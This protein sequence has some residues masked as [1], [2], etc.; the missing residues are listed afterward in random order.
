MS[1]GWDYASGLRPPT[2]LVFVGQVIY[3]HGQPRWN[4][5]DRTNPKN[6][7][8]NL[9][10]CHF[11][12]HKS[13]NV[14]V[15]WLTLLVCIREVSGSNISPETGYRDCFSWFSSVPAGKCRDSTIKLGNGPFLSHPFQFI[16]HLWS[17]HSTLH[18][19]RQRKSVAKKPQINKSTTTPKRTDLSTSPGLRGERPVTN[20]LSHGMACDRS[21][22]WGQ[23]R[24]YPSG[25]RLSRPNG[26]L[27]VVV[28]APVSVCEN[29]L[30]G[31]RL[32]Q[33]LNIT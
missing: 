32:V 15:E 20:R 14:V 33:Y 11:V 22:C 19:L 6:S 10:Q 21:Y 23:R 3:E 29:N 24:R 26:R 8:K 5:T 17:F 16:L 13:L 31:L 1:T 30:T 25:N 12:H 28:K 18:S 4:D 27:D 7:D 2:G 9:S